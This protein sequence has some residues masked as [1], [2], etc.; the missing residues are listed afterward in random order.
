MSLFYHKWCFASILLATFTI[1]VGCG[2]DPN[3]MTS[4]RQA[5]PTKTAF[6]S[7]WDAT[8]NRNGFIEGQIVLPNNQF[9][10]NIPFDCHPLFRT[11][12]GS[13]DIGVLTTN[14]GKYRCGGPPGRYKFTI[15]TDQVP[16]NSWSTEIEV[17]ARQTIIQDI[18]ITP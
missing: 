3:T 10:A 1:L 11:S 4:D 8:T 16:G 15:F 9:A 7:W 17:K 13:T 12:Q 2:E 18:V 5:I 6:Q 14:Q